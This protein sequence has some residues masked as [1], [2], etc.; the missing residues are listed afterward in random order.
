MDLQ[1]MLL[2]TPI[3]FLK[4]CFQFTDTVFRPH[5]WIEVAAVIDNIF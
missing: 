3:M 1:F 2:S 4:F 5:L